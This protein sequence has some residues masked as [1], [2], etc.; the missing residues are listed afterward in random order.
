MAVAVAIRWQ[1]ARQAALAEEM[2]DLEEG[3]HRLFSRMRQDR[4]PDGALLDIHDAHGWI[5]LGKDL[6]CGLI[7]DAL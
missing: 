1:L 3:D 4:Q 7:L 5:P 6:S 2:A